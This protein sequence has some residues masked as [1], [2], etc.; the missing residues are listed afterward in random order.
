MKQK[1]LELEGEISKPT[2]LARAF[3]TVLKKVKNKK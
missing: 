2:V 3:S 1:L